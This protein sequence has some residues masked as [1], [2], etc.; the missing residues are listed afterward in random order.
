MNTLAMLILFKLFSNWFKDHLFVHLI[1]N[2]QWMNPIRKLAELTKH[3]MLIQVSWTLLKCLPTNWEGSW[4]EAI[5]HVRNYLL[6][7]PKQLLTRLKTPPLNFTNK[8]IYNYHLMTVQVIQHLRAQLYKDVWTNHS[9]S[10][11]V[12]PVR[13]SQQLSKEMRNSDKNFV[14]SC[15]IIVSYISFLYACI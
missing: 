9:P 2:M 11:L 4:L 3:P 6:H 10:S 12:L 8:W 15:G 5:H 7:C 14:F 13:A 1:I